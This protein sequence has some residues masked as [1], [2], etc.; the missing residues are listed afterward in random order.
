VA[1]QLGHLLRTQV[2]SP[3]HYEKLALA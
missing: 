1:V 2:G 3:V